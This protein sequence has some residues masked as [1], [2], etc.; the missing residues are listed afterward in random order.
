[1]E[2]K[3]IINWLNEMVEG[4]NQLSISWEGGNDSGWAFFKVDDE[5]VDNEYTESLVEYMYNTLDYGSWAGEFSANGT[6]LYDAKARAFI[7]TD[8][9]S[10]DENDSITTNITIKIPKKLWFE[11]L[12]IEC[13]SNY[14]ETPNMS[15]RFLIKNGFLT[16][17][18][19][20]FC[21]NLEESFTEQFE[22][23]FNNYESSDDHEFRSCNDIWT[24]ERKDAIE[25]DDMLVFKITNIE[26]GIMDS[27]EKDIVLKLTDEIIETIDENLNETENEN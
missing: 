4:G 27:S 6:A 19:S 11:T 8:Y 5:Q 18:H 10:Y 12:R 2:K 3:S 14:D 22:E 9:Y 21:S 20:D 26:I 13:E 25:E 23:L 15:V 16:Q 17:E 24:L 1:M 7:G